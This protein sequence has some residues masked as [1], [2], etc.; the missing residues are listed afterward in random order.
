MLARPR[1]GLSGS[2]VASK[3]TPSS[4]TTSSRPPLAAFNLELREGTAAEAGRAIA[5]GLRESGG[6]LAGVRA[7]AIELAWCGV[8]FQPQSALARWYA[9]RWATGG[10]RGRKVGIVAVA[11]RLLIDLWR[12]VDAGVV[13]DGARFKPTAVVTASR[14][15]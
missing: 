10:V 2:R 8:Q 7:I 13:P 3:P 6:G 11:R 12:Y 15:T 14:P 5:A 9:A 1:L 4:V